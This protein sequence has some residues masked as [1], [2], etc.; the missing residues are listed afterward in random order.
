M[1]FTLG[2]AGN[3]P[4]L[5]GALPTDDVS[6]FYCHFGLPP[7]LL[8]LPSSG[9]PAGIRGRRAVA[10]FGLPSPGSALLGL[11][12]LALALGFVL[13]PAMEAICSG[14][15]IFRLADFLKAIKRPSGIT[16]SH[17]P[18]ILPVTNAALQI[19]ALSGHR[20]ALFLSPRRPGR[21]DNGLSSGMK[22]EDVAAGALLCLCV[23]A[24][25]EFSLVQQDGRS[26][27][28]G[29]RQ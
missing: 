23:G 29:L 26:V 8:A 15:T 4:P 7:F 19:D 24:F 16:H 3:L 25:D 9:P 5:P 17:M 18:D 2:L 20:Y 6:A 22:R 1:L 21:S 11:A 10:R 27:D 12:S 13:P 28:V 14:G